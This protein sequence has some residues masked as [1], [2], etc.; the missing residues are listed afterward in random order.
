VA[1]SAGVVD[2]LPFDH[3]FME[4]ERPPCLR[5]RRSHPSWPGGA[6]GLIFANYV[7]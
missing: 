1:Q 3:I 7:I 5:L 2:Q 4:L 6:I